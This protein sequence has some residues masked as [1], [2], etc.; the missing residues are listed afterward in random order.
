M[1]I[2]EEYVK[3][4]PNAQ[5]AIDIFGGEWLS[6]FPAPFDHLKGGSVPLFQDAR[7]KWAAEILGGFEGANILE[8]GPLEGGHSY[9]LERQ[10]AASVLAI[11]ANR[12]AYMKCLI[13]KELFQLQR[14]RFMLGD[15]VEFLRNTDQQFDVC[16]ASGVLYHMQNPVELLSLI[17]DHAEKVMLWTH[18]YD[19]ELIKS[20]PNLQRGHFSETKFATFG[21][22][23]H[24]LYQLNYLES[25]QSRKFAGAGSTFSYWMTRE[26]ILDGLE[27]FGYGTLE[28]AFESTG[29]PHGPCFAVSA[30]KDD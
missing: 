9:M 6:R 25:L 27:Y 23:K 11:E 2:L 14:V 5:N 19:E 4:A 18:Y 3:S 10:R 21:G 13:I 1:D 30:I 16:I 15:F 7:I 26:G 22:F 20:N 8:L 29:H 17:A 12:R 24:R 28:I